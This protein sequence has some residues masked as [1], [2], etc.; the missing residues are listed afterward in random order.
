M[1]S[2][3]IHPDAEDDLADLWNSDA[4]AAAL[5]TVA[6]E[7][8]QGDQR[9]L[10]GLTIHGFGAD[11]DEELIEVKKWLA[12]WNKGRDIWRF[13]IWDVEQLGTPYRIVYAYEV[14]ERRYTVLGI[15]HRSFN[16]DPSHPLSLRVKNAYDNL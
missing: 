3:H 2:L 9:L 14:G 13:K 16:Y 15:F 5:I 7:E 6:L 12:F 1:Y 10:D 4:D 8:I 11:D